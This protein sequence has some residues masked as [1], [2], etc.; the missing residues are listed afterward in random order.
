MRNFFSSV[1]QEKQ[2]NNMANGDELEELEEYIE[3]TEIENG[4]DEGSSAVQGSY[5]GLQACSFRDM[6]LKPELQ[7]AIGDAG[8]EHQS[9]VQQNAIPFAMVGTDMIVQAKSGMGK[10]AVFVMS[11]LQQIEIDETATEKK[12]DTLVLCHAREL[13]YQISKEFTRFSKY[14]SAVKVGVV[15]GGVPFSENKA[16]IKNDCPNILIGTPGRVLHLLNEGGLELDGLKR[17]ILDECDN[18][19]EG[20][21]DMRRQ[22]QQIFKKTPHEKQVMLYSATISPEARVLCKKFCKNAEEI[23]VDDKKLT[24]HGLQQHFVKLGEKEKIKKLTDLLDALDFNQVVIFVKTKQRADALNRVLKQAMFPSIT[25]HANLK[26]QERLER[27]K[28]FKEYKARILIATD[29]LGRGVDVERVNIVVNFDMTSD[30]NQYLHRVGRAGRFGTKGLAIT[31]I[32]SEEDQKI[33]DDVQSRFE[34]KVTE[35]PNEIE[36]STYMAN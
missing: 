23:F 21:L 13:A 22:V 3:P 29:L 7:R 20:G 31:F 10:T 33:L 14:L 1:K 2:K 6:L 34:V 24:L 19:L 12:V 36:T 16:L 25:I 9:E 32:E 30:S 35:L 17:F 28:K 8:F 5:A 18:L 26:Q 27:Y 15:Y 4:D 11:T